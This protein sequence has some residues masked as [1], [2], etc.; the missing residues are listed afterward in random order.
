MSPPANLAATARQ[1][2]V[3]RLAV[4]RNWQ[5]VQ[6]QHIDNPFSLVIVAKKYQLDLCL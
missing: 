2:A 5:H 6:L 3:Q 4:L 1:A